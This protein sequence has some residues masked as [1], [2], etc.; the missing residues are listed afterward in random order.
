MSFL[1]ISIA[2]NKL[3]DVTTFDLVILNAGILGDISKTNNLRVDQFQDIFT[4]NVLANKV[5]IDWLLNHNIDIKNIIGI[6]TGAALKTYYGWSLYCTSKAAFKQLISSYA[7]ETPDIHFI[8]LAPGI[9]KTK[10][11]KKI[12]LNKNDID[13]LKKFKKLYINDKMDYPDTVATKIINYLNSRKEKKKN[14][15]D[16]RNIN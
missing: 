11:Q 14:Y 4:V 3:I 13:S 8:S 16:L 15:V 1:Q 12:F 9:I 7:Q 5:I 6:S 10:M 2:L